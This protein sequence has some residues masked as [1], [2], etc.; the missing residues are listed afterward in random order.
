MSTKPRTSGE[1]SSSVLD[2]LLDDDKAKAEAKALEEFQAAADQH[3]KDFGLRKSQN[4]LDWNHFATE[5]AEAPAPV[6]HAALHARIQGAGRNGT[7]PQGTPV[8]K[9]KPKED[10]PSDK[11]E[12]AVAE[13]KPMQQVEDPGEKIQLKPIPRDTVQEPEPPRREQ[14]EAEKSNPRITD[15]IMK[16]LPASD[17]RAATIVGMRRISS[18]DASASGAASVSES[19]PP[20]AQPRA[21][22]PVVLP[23]RSMVLPLLLLLGAGLVG[24][25]VWYFLS[26]KPGPKPE[27][28]ASA[29]TSPVGT[30]QSTQIASSPTTATATAD[31]TSSTTASAA[32]PSATTSEAASSPAAKSSTPPATTTSAAKTSKP[33]ATAKPTVTI[34]PIPTPTITTTA[35][36]KPWVTD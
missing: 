7:A 22:E 23:K 27:P 10:K 32:P 4:L 1:V 25:I 19:A 15:I 26:S 29:V 33:S 13:L 6:D 35:S 30:P 34:P 5:D 17:A 12:Y 20:N 8:A 24:G 11:A 16:K 9:P 36:T 2:R 14:S 18:K 3:R 21:T 28:T 31:A